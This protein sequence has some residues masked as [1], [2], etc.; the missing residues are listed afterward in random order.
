MAA[1]P[2]RTA[3]AD[4]Y[5]NPTNAMARTG[6]GALWD[7]VT[8]LL[9][10]TGN[11]AEARV[12]LGVLGLGGGALTGPLNEAHGA[13]IVSSGTINLT[14][15]TGNVVDVTGTTNITAITLADGAERTVRFTGVLTLTHGAALVLPGGASIATAAGD[16]AVFRGYAAGVVRCVA[17]TRASGAA[18]VAPGAATSTASGIVELATTAETETGTDTTRVV[19]PAGLAAALASSGVGFGAGQTWQNMTSS[20]TSG[21]T[22]T[23]STGKPIAVIIHHIYVA[24]TPTVGGLVLGTDQ[25]GNT[26]TN[27]MLFFVVPDGMTYSAT[28][29]AEAKWMELR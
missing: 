19:T 18:V 17:Y 29:G 14:T 28:F 9:G 12:A 3:L 25:G 22:Y 8:G 11:A 20:R 16:F 21:T 6:L 15:A 4:T 5:P 10:A 13:D 1:P 23:N 2:L 24:V 27:T 26:N 7:Y